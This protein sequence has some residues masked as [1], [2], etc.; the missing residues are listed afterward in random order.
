MPPTPPSFR[1]GRISESLPDSTEK[2]RS[3]V[4]W[5]YAFRFSQSP[6]ESLA[7]LMTSTSLASRHTVSGSSLLPVRA[8]M[9]YSTMGVST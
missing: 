1:A 6:L 5:I 2:S 7:P 3:F 4:S 8:G 9:L